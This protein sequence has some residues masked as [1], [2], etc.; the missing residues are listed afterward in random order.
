MKVDPSKA[1]SFITFD[2]SEM[3]LKIKVNAG[4]ES[5]G[6]V[7]IKLKLSAYTDERVPRLRTHTGFFILEIL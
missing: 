7:L 4:T 6:K 2:T 5:V 1:A 3:K